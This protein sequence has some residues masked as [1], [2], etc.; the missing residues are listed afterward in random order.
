MTWLMPR[1][2]LGSL[3]NEPA[4]LG[5]SPEFWFR[6][7]CLTPV[8]LWLVGFWD[9]DD[10]QKSKA[11]KTDGYTP[12]PHACCEQKGGVSPSVELLLETGGFWAVD[13]T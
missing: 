8:F 3:L 12:N 6:F 11:V 1:W 10:G 7:R 13:S 5:L 9:V 2:I 4:Q